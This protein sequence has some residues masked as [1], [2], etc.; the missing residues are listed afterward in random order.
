M[1][2][3]LHATT[4]MIGALRMLVTAHRVSPNR[5]SLYGMLLCIAF[6]I[7]HASI[8]QGKDATV[9]HGGTTISLNGQWKAGLNRNY[10]ETLTVPG[11]AEDPAMASAGTLWY[12]RTVQLPAGWDY[13]GNAG[14]YAGHLAT[15]ST[16]SYTDQYEGTPT[17]APVE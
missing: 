14:W 1:K 17:P 2:T 10:T 8:A 6:L 15:G 16:A 12:K 3:G 13:A 9:V 5:P 11:L 4:C 7:P